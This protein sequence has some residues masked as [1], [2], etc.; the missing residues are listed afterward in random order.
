[1]PVILMEDKNKKT[2]PETV[3]ETMNPATGKKPVPETGGHG[4][5]DPSRFGDWEI[6]GK[7][8]DF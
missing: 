1:M 8:V 6:A 7:C 3:K 2:A 5:L 4:G